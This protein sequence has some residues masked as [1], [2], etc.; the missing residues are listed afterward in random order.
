MP[1]KLLNDWRSSTPRLLRIEQIA[2]N[3]TPIAEILKIDFQLFFQSCSYP[4]PLR[5]PWP[6]PFRA[7]KHLFIWRRCRPRW[8]FRWSILFY[9][10]KP[11]G[12]YSEWKVEEDAPDAGFPK[13][14]FRDCCWLSSCN[15]EMVGRYFSFTSCQLERISSRNVFT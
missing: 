13:K 15:S 9:I 11:R 6:S 14:S 7:S 10:C 1:L 4:V 12:A 2:F 8:Y 3:S 5:K